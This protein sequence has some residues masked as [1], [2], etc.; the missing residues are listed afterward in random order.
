M[1]KKTFRTCYGHYK[2]LVMLF[3]LTNAPTIFMDLMNQVFK[4]YFD[5]FVVVFIDDILIYPCSQTEHEQH[6]R[7]VLE[8]LRGNQLYGKRGGILRICD[9]RKGHICGS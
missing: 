4:P 6:L 1:S 9:V 2:F 7:T 3:R 8:T 5:S